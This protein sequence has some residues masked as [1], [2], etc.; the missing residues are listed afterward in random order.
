M[1]MMHISL[2]ASGVFKATRRAQIIV[3][4]GA[5]SC[6]TGR[7]RF[8]LTTSTNNKLRTKVSTIADQYAGKW[9]FLTHEMAVSQICII[10]NE[11]LCRTHVI[12]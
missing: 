7:K 12:D 11:I 6:L 2:S 1:H 4:C 5:H 3:C 8:N 9:K 10:K